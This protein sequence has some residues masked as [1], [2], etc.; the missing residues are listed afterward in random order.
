MADILSQ[1]MR[2]R[3][4]L[5]AIVLALG[6]VVLATSASDD[7]N[8][9]NGALGAN[10]TQQITGTS[11]VIVSNHAE[12][13][14]SATSTWAFYTTGTWANDQESSATITCGDSSYEGVSV[15]MSGV[16]AAS[17]NYTY[18]TDCS[19]ASQIQK[20]VAGVDTNLSV[21]LS[22]P[23]SGSVIKLRAVGTTLTAYD[24]GVSIGS[25][26]DADLA[27]GKP[28]IFQYSSGGGS[29][30]LDDWLGADVGGGG[31]GGTPCLRALLGVGCDARLMKSEHHARVMR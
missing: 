19:S 12:A 21:G 26:G 30:W 27:S 24:D 25:I 16:D 18:V 4:S 6:V 22:I 5:T 14:T 13:N 10:W 9:A 11:L 8:R 3:L 23:A 28:G 31:G 17:N 20:R 1:A 15:R 7:F 2:F 29:S